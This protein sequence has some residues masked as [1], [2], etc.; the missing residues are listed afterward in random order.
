MENKKM[1][2]KRDIYLISGLFVFFVALFLIFQFVIYT[3][4]SAYAYIYYGVG[5]PI[6]SIDFSK[7]EVTQNFVQDVPEAYTTTYPVINTDT[8]TDGYVEVTLLGDY[9]INGVRQEVVILIDFNQNRIKVES[10]QS[11]LNICSNQGWSTAA[12]LICLPNKVR[13]EFDSTTSNVDFIQ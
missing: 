4:N 6:V 10:E 12:P 2:Q 1:I 8:G 5:D 13:V 9:E 11:P 3:G 7:K